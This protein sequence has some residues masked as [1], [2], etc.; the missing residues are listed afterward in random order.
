MLTYETC[1]NVD[2]E[3]VKYEY[4]ENGKVIKKYIHSKY[5]PIT[6][7]KEWAKK[8]YDKDTRVYIV[9]G[10][11]LLY[12][13]F[14]LEKL[15]G[16]DDSIIIF[17]P[18]KELCEKVIASGIK[19]ND[20]VTYTYMN[21]NDN[22]NI[23][24]FENNI[25]A[26]DYK[27]IKICAYNLYESIFPK[28]VDRLYEYLKSFAQSTV[29][30]LRTVISRYNFTIEN[31]IKHYRFF[32]KGTRSNDIKNLYKGKTA[33]IVSSGPS[34]D[35][36]VADLRGYED[37]AV[38]ITGGRSLRTLLDNG[39][40]AHMVA[41][42]D[43]TPVNYTSI[44]QRFDI[45]NETIPLATLLESNYKITREYK[46]DKIFIPSDS[47]DEKDTFLYDEKTDSLYC[48]GSVAILQISLA[49]YLG[50]ERIIF[51]GQDLAYKEDKLYSETSANE[52]NNVQVREKDIIYVKGNVQEKVKTNIL[53][54][55]FNT[56]IAELIRA[57]KNI[58]F[59]NATEGGA[60]IDGTKVMTLKGALSSI[61]YD[62]ENLE[63]KLKKVI[64][65]SKK[66]I[67]DED[68]IKKL[69][70]VLE[71][72]EYVKTIAKRGRLETKKLVPYVSVNNSKILEK[73][74]KLDKKIEKKDKLYKFIQGFLYELGLEA[75]SNQ[76]DDFEHIVKITKK[77]YEDIE[78][79]SNI[80][81]KYLQEE[82][83]YIK[84]DK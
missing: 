28:D 70:S 56:G 23:S 66:D 10:G 9:Y 69:K 1:K 47:I 78:Y 16:E 55:M 8:V 67:D 65:D 71:D 51:I 4:E 81:K 68:I 14:E 40:R 63:E 31:L 77:Q 33:V 82:I 83:E 43:M 36:N 75:I 6:E 50:C 42:I 60:Y 38:I 76:K 7:A 45:L 57:N 20:N 32:K 62:G 73:L 59:I 26:Y 24:F 52:N 49:L 25:S 39:I 30:N 15:I 29:I 18:I 2:L 54:N 64:E 53:L 79:I 34:L 37:K 21:E 27:S 72:V 12:H 48:Y 22:E 61:E 41:T 11:G 17:E 44:Y 80:M 13:I 58:E 5:D 35:D 84:N 3:T 19:F 46:G 74:E